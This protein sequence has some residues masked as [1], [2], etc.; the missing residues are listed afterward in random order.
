MKL[1]ARHI[2]IILIVV[3]AT[4]VSTFSLIK[5]GVLT[6]ADSESY[7]NAFNV[8]YSGGID[9]FRTPI[10]PIFIGIIRYVFGQQ[11]YTLA[12][13][14]IQHLLFIISLPFFFI[15]SERILRSTLLSIILSVALVFAVEFANWN[16]Y[17]MT[18]SLSTSLFILLLFSLFTL[19]ESPSVLKFCSC[20]ICSVIVLL[21]RPAFIYLIPA[22]ALFFIILI[23]CKKEKKASAFYC[24]AVSSSLIIVTTAYFIA[25]HSLYGVYAFSNVSTVNK[26]YTLRQNGLI[27]TS[28][29]SN[30]ALVADIEYFKKVNGE[31][32]KFIRGTYYEIQTLDS[33]YPLKDIDEIITTSISR[34]KAKCVS[35]VLDRFRLAVTD[36]D[37][38]AISFKSII[39]NKIIYVY[40]VLLLASIIIIWGFI[41]RKKTNA[42]LLILYTLAMGHFFV[43]F[44]GAQGD[45]HRLFEPAMP[46]MLLLAGILFVDYIKPFLIRSRERNRRGVASTR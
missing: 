21:L 1:H 24:L 31:T 10:Y 33:I 34:N 30:Q 38:I 27:D 45:W 14:I 6:T 36:Y 22:F 2:F 23:L 46:V 19:I 17:I 16:N 8:Y 44:I 15:L 3:S 35:L 29:S 13:I 28:N 37:T 42:I 18:E 40:S 11:Y 26:Y 25:F 43:T 12:I 7:I 5:H 39:K 20:L 41:R 4:I 32:N 9:K